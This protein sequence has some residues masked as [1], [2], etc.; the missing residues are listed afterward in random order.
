MQK[1][2]QTGLAAGLSATSGFHSSKPNGLPK[3]YDHSRE[4]LSQSFVPTLDNQVVYRGKNGDVTTS[5]I[6]IGAWPWGDTSTWHY[7]EK[8]LPAIKEA[9]QVL[10]Q[11]GV[12]HIDTAQVYGS[13]RSEDIC[14]ELVKDLPRDEFVMQTKFWVLPVD[15]TNLIHWSTAPYLKLKESLARFKLDYIDVYMIHGH[16]HAQGIATIAKSLAQCVEE[17]LTK[18]VA[19]ANYSKEDMLEMQAELKKYGIP[20]A[21]NQCEYSVLRRQPEV[22]GLLRAC[23][24]NDIVFQSYSSLAQSRLTGKWSHENEPPKTYRFSSYPMKEIEP[25]TDVLRRIAEAHGVTVAAVALNYNMV[26][27]IV[28]VVGVRNAEQAR[29]NAQALGWRLS[30]EEIREIDAVSFQGKETS[31]W[32]QG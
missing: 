22:S 15:P 24:E 17:G 32:Q 16:I 29:S 23:K 26:H 21:C 13:G 2:L 19:V 9:W 20:L 1:I 12:N 25:T 28:P 5:R 11:S 4:V 14:G 31:L 10:L 3:D 6:C 27:G 7:D 8:E 18:T 30:D